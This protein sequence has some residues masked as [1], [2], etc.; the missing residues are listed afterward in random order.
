MSTI[1]YLN[2]KREQMKKFIRLLFVG[3]VVG[4]GLSGF[5]SCDDNITIERIESVSIDDL[6]LGY[7]ITGLPGSPD[8]P[9]S[10]EFCGS[11]AH[12]IYSSQPSVDE[13]YNSNGTGID[14][15]SDYFY[16]SNSLIEFGKSYFF[17]V[18]DAN[19][20]VT[21]IEKIECVPAVE[22]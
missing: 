5:T 8:V 14:F 16:G 6:G 22:F 21:G 20:T 9:V 13:V 2:N 19:W 15:E 1:S 12:L 7:H 4:L 11:I 18:A 10:I 17:E 3:L